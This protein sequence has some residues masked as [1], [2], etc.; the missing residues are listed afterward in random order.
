[1]EDIFE[2]DCICICICGHQAWAHNPESCALCLERHLSVDK[3]FHH[4]KLD[5]LRFIEDLAKKRN[6]IN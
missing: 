4:F 2:M 5:N 3:V 1:M 6:L